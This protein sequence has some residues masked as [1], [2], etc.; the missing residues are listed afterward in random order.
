MSAK[1]LDTLVAKAG[2]L[3]AISAVAKRVLDL[4]NA[5]HATAVILGEA[6][7]KDQSLAAHILKV[8]N[9]AFYSLP[10]EIT[11]LPMAVSVLGLR[12]LRDQI[13]VA[14]TRGTYK[15][16]GITEKMLWSH[17]VACAIAARLLA[18]RYAPLRAEDAFICGLLHDVGKVILDNE[19]PSE[20]TEAMMLIYNEGYSSIRAEKEIFG[21][22]HTQVGAM[23][24]RN[25]NYPPI[26]T[27]VTFQHHN[28]EEP[29]PPIDDP[30]LLSVLACVDLANL[31]C[32][33]LG[34]GYRE[35]KPE[36]SM[37]AQPAAEM[38]NI[39]APH[40]AELVDRVKEAYEKESAGWAI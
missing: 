21:Y 15:R 35:P 16:F 25:W 5:D 3:R 20:F 6:L 34:I 1:N 14:T 11:T 33:V 29:R 19:C 31:T 36:T 24:S 4:I 10:R 7:S 23:I 2:D 9:S 18:K 27:E 30:D 13:L 40:L 22:S 28:N 38:L 37:E 17:S 12:N 39:P 26:I 8:A 32:K